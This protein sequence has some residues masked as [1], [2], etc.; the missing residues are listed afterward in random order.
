MKILVINCGSSSVKADLI[1]TV[2]SHNLISCKIDRINDK[3]P[4]L[5]FS[6]ETE[7]VFLSEP[8]Y[9][10]SLSAAFNKMKSKPLFDGLKGVG[11]RIVHGGNLMSEPVIINED[12]E[13]EIE[14]L[15]I[16]APLHNPA[17]LTGVRLAKQFFQEIPHVAVFDT[18][19]HHTLPARASTYALPKSMTNKH[20]LRRYGFHGTSHEYVAGKAAEYLQADVRDLRIITCHL[21]NGASVCAVEY[22]RSVETSMGMTPLEGLVMGTRS[23]D[24]DAGILFHLAEQENLDIHTLNNLL[25]KQS[26]LLGLTDGLSNDMRDIEKRAA[27]GDENCREAINIFSHRL[28]KYIGAYAAVM[29]GADAIIFTA[30]IGE[31]SATIRH[32]VSQRLDF[33]GA[34]LDED[35][36]RDVKVSDS[37]PVADISTRN[38]RC[39]I[40][41]VAT[42]EELAIARLSA[43]EIIE[44][45]NLKAIK[46]IPIAVSARHVHLTQQTVEELFGVGYQLTVRNPLSQPGQY[47]C[48]ETVTLIGPKNHLEKVRILGPVRSKDQV[49]ISRTDEFFLGIDAPVRE[50]GHTENTPG[51]TLLGTDNRKVTLKEGVICAWRHIHMHPD[52][53]EAFQVKDKDIVEVEVRNAERSLTFGDVIIRVSEQFKLEMHIDTDEANA[54]E[55]TNGVVGELHTT[56]ASGSLKKKKLQ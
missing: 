10:K 34:I 6:D 9:E 16:L 40:L 33:L 32:R 54:A 36:N 3:N 7:S 25:N 4:V 37:K 47:A 26:G 55:I 22:G 43:K 18:A 1:D 19:F 31:N 21:G 52:D 13:K 56:D 17:N 38:S 46:A 42:D 5:S 51:L 48:N 30:G 23:G 15:F 20:L 28:R 35:E 50:S 41:V 45:R 12:I 53:A 11:H 2:T 14:K 44:D 39:K 27:E 49:E 8:G 24:I 29:G